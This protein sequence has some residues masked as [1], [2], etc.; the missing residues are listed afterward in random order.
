[1]VEVVKSVNVVWTAAG[2][3]DIVGV[4]VIRRVAGCFRADVVLVVVWTFSTED[5][6]IR[7]LHFK[8]VV[9]LIDAC[10]QPK[11]VRNITKGNN[12]V[13]IASCKRDEIKEV[14]ED[15]H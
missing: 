15:L 6:P 4:D 12:I 5:F 10:T 3:I 9:E 1:M 7:V 2:V 8:I 13:K 14:P 11:R